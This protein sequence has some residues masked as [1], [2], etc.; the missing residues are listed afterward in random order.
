[1]ALPVSYFSQ[2]QNDNTLNS[3]GTPESATWEVAITTL[4]AANVVAKTALIDA[5]VTAVNSITLGQPARQNTVFNREQLS[6][7]PAVSIHAQRENKLLLRY[8]GNVANKLF[9][10]T[11]PCFDLEELPDNG[12]FL[13][14]TAGTGAALKTAFEAIVV[15]PDDSS[16]S[17]S[18]LSAQFVGRNT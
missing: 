17:V 13:D 15:S 3:Q 12:E 18:L 16:E 11:L 1:M 4:T 8:T 14:L 2:T 10:V 6:R 7:L 5:L 9:R